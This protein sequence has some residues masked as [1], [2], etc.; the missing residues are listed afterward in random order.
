MPVEV[1]TIIG[2]GVGMAGIFGTL[3]WRLSKDGEAKRGR[4]YQ[5]LDEI[6]RVAKQEFTMKDVCVERHQNI[7]DKMD[8]AASKMDGIKTGIKEDMVGIREDMV[9]IR[10]DMKELKGDVKMLLRKNGVG[11]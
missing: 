3:V 7:A 6:K 11:K 5:R 4:I 1:G 10:E 8:S 9:G 2:A